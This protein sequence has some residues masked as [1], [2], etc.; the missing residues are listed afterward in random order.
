MSGVKDMQ[1]PK[2][3]AAFGNSYGC[4]PIHAGAAE[5]CD[6]LILLRQ[7]LIRPA[8]LLLD[9]QMDEVQLGDHR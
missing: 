2:K 9:H 8:A 6:L 7:H 4:T 3:I 1:R 5:G